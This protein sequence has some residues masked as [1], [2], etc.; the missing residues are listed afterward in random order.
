MSRI[1]QDYTAVTAAPG[2]RDGFQ[3]EQVSLRQ[4][5]WLPLNGM[6]GAPV[7]NSDASQNYSRSQPVIDIRPYPATIGWISG[8]LPLMDIWR[9]GNNIARLPGGPY[10]GGD[11]VREQGN[12]EFGVNSSPLKVPKLLG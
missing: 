10:T 9:W 5:G 3:L 7:V 4:L 12:T 8:L 1:T 2:A 6:P 11:H